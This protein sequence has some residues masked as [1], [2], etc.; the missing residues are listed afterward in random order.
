MAILSVLEAVCA[1][2]SGRIWGTG[3][4]AL[5]GVETALFVVSS[6]LVPDLELVDT[7]CALAFGGG[8][9][10]GGTAGIGGKVDTFWKTPFH[11]AVLHLWSAGAG[12]AAV[13]RIHGCLDEGWARRREGGWR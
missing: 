4:D 12:T 1:T 13:L 6:S 3:A 5:G 11:I 8:K 7:F 2:G 10:G 9:W